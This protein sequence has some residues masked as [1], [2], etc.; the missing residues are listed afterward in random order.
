M[1]GPSPQ[2]R[3]VRT[4]AELSFTT[5]RSRLVSLLLR[6][7]QKNG[8]RTPQAVQI[9]LPSSNQELDPQIGTVREL[10]SRN[11][12]RLQP[13]GIIQIDGRI[14][15]IHDLRALERELQTAER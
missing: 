7:A 6:T 5:V 2:R 14:A 3:L 13:E 9:E 10:V 15:L 11:L 12:S 4:I 1:S 8:K